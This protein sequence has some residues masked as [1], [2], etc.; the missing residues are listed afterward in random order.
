MIMAE[1]EKQD[2]ALE[3][4]AEQAPVTEPVVEPPPWPPKVKHGCC[5]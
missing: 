4:T 5:G 3:D 2:T 1:N